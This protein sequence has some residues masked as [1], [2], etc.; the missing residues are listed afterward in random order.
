MRSNFIGQTYGRL[1]FLDSYW[2]ISLTWF[3][4]P[5]AATFTPRLPP[6]PHPQHLHPSQQTLLRVGRAVL[7]GGG[8]SG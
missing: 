5:A 6:P 3:Y 1:I 7:R 8:R 4:L 2:T